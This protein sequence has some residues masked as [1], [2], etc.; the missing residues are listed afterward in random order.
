MDLGVMIEGQEGL[1]WDRWRRIIRTTEDLG[2]ESLFRSDHFFSLSGP[3]DRDALETFISFVLVAEESSRISFGPLVSSMTFRH[4]SLLARMAAQIDLLS[5]GRFI[6][7]MGAGWNVP[8]H[9]AFGL[10]FP[11]VRERMDRLEEG[12]QVVR[13]LWGDGPVSF[14]GRYYQLKDAECFPKP[15]QSPAPILVG[16][17]G[18]KRTLRIVA[19][20]ADEWNAV[21][22]TIEGYQHKNEVLLGHCDAVGRDASTIRRSMMCGFVIGRD[23]DGVRAH[24]ARIGEALPMLTRGNPDEVLEGVR[25]RGWLVGTTSEVVEQIKQREELGIQR[26][27]LQH[28]AQADFDTLEL[29]AKDVLPQVQR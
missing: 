11:P 7:G 20:Y 9:E 8:E 3:H 23:E 2:F 25:N 28:H 13:A 10:P 26:I 22:Q 29:I 18:E 12:I 6:L 17:S 14:D 27:M 24:L 1:N 16:G 21:G 19:K 4:P 5:G 15:A